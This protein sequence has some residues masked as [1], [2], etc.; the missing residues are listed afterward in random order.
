MKRYFGRLT[1]LVLSA[2]MAVGTSMTIYANEPGMA[3]ISD[4]DI[5]ENDDKV[6]VILPT[7][8]V[9]IFDFILDPQE[10]INKTNAA[11]YEGKIF[12][13]GATLFFKRSESESLVDYSSTSD[14][15]TITNNGSTPVD[16]VITADIIVSAG[17]EFAMTDDREF[18]DDKRPSLYLA[19]TD[20]ETEVPILGEG[21]KAASL[22]ITIPS[23][24]EE[25]GSNEC[26]FRLTGAA[27]KEGDWHRMK[28][29]SFEVSV[30]WVVAAEEEEEVSENEEIDLPKEQDAAQPVSDSGE[31]IVRKIVPVVTDSNA[32]LNKE[33]R[34]TAESEKGVS[35]DYDN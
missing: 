15:V 14:A 30:T 4:S 17:E 34:G 20:G 9:G 8:S 6:R 28:D 10:L 3:R 35:H 24:S 22:T 21:E 11:A 7:D 29:I 18:T 5:T 1:A 33:E 25:E 19:L 13:E 23:V 16:I 2:V 26:S 31:E 27:N 12:E 32:A